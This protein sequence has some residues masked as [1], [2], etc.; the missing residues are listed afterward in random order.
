MIT[1]D[2]LV[3]YSISLYK[4]FLLISYYDQWLFDRIFL[5]CKMLMFD[6]IGTFL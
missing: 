1:Y 6:V 5:N 4:Y 2:F 3:T